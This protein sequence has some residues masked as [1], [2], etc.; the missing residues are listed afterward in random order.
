MKKEQALR[1]ALVV[2]IGTGLHFGFRGLSSA[3]P[4]KFPHLAREA[5][6]TVEVPLLPWES[7]LKPVETFTEI[8]KQNE[9]ELPTPPADVEP[10]QPLAP[11]QAKNAVKPKTNSVRKLV[12]ATVLPETPV[13]SLV[14]DR[15]HGNS[16]FIITPS[17]AAPVEFWARIY[18]VYTSDQV[19]L[20]DMED[21]SIVYKILDF[22]N[23]QKRD[24]SDAERRSI[25]ESEVNRAM[26]EIR[27]GLDSTLA[28]RLRSQTGMKN[29]FEEGLKRSGRYISYFE[30]IIISY[31]MPSEIS[32]LPFVESLFNEKAFSKVAAGGL[33]QF[34]AESAKKYMTVNSLVDERYDPL[35]AC[36]GAAKLLRHNFDLLGTWPL[37]INAYN[38]G[39]GN[40]MK[41]MN[42]LGT[43]DIAKIINGYRGGSYAFASRNFYPS[44]LAALHVY[45]NRK[46]YF[47]NIV[48]DPPLAFDIL[49]LPTTMSFPEIA[50]L[51][52]T[53]LNALKSLNPAFD[54]SVIRGAYSLPPGSQLRVPPGVLNAFAARFLDFKASPDA[55]DLHIVESGETYESIAHFYETSSHDMRQLNNLGADLQDGFVVQIPPTRHLVKREK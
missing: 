37:A 36:H 51:S 40:L 4:Q 9:P 35:I 50:Y 55:P 14:T 25:R 32:R 23:L 46:K 31:G 12:S 33:W 47:G 39:P 15:Y 21:L 18:G 13:G 28:N 41:A 43:K 22:S 52:Q 38:S 2:S 29:R 7:D 5:T 17:L 11:L 19:V 1:I 24:I 48:I 45:E 54:A 8:A 53:S 49:E 16:P 34:M 42:A 27:A 44:F 30:K 26:A 10:L 6:P 3:L 20:H